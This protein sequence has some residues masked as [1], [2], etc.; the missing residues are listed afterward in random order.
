[1]IKFDF[2]YNGKRIQSNNRFTERWYYENAIIGMKYEVK[3]L[4]DAPNKNSFNLY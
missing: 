2:E 3:Y 1:M 4:T